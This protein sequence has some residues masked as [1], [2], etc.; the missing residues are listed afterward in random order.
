MKLG[1]KL[2]DYITYQGGWAV[3]LVLGIIGTILVFIPHIKQYIDSMSLWWLCF[4]IPLVLFV[5]WAWCIL[6][7]LIK[8]NKDILSL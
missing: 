7:K 2:Y 4:D 5:L 8:K 3:V 1:K 6:F